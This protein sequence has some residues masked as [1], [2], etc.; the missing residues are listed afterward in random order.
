MK[1]VY[2]PYAKNLSHILNAIEDYMISGY[3]DGKDSPKRRLR[4]VPGFVDDAKRI[5]T[6][7]PD[8]LKRIEKVSELIS[9]FETFFGLKLLA[10]IH[11]LVENG[12]DS[13]NEVIKETYAWDKHKAQFNQRQIKIALHRLISLQWI[14][15]LKGYNL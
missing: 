14:A 11:W 15:P 2:G 12:V 3:I 5:L 7:R 4:L 9:G 13:L 1:G 10:T 6:V 8:T